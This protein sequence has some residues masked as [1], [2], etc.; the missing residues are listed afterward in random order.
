M[1]HNEQITIL[2]HIMNVVTLTLFF[3]ILVTQSLID[4]HNWNFKCSIIQKLCKKHNKELCMCLC[5]SVCV[6]ACVYNMFVFVCMCISVSECVYKFC[7][8]TAP[9]DERAWR[10]NMGEITIQRGRF[11]TILRTADCFFY[12]TF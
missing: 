8:K 1:I 11:Q 6:Y 7:N 5:V 4:Y 3:S 12:L 2:K 10:I 9:L